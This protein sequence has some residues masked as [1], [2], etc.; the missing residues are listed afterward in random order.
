MN[1]SEGQKQRL[2]LARALVKDPDILV[3]DEPTSAL[4]SL[5]ERSIFQS[6][7]ALVQDKTLFVVAYRLSTIRDSHRIL[8][9][10]ER[11]LVAIGT[12]QSLMETNDYYR[13][14]VAYQQM[15]AETE[16]PA[17]I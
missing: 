5:A 16:T 15:R 6:L 1:L 2:S 7:S 12:H 3:L 8:L 10:N 11:R 9:L 4:D 14:V 13:S 17:V